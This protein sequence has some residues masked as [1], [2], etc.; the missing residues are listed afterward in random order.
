MKPQSA[1]SV[2]DPPPTGTTH[3]WANVYKAIMQRAHDTLR[4]KWGG[5]FDVAAVK[6]P[7][8]K[9]GSFSVWPRGKKE[10]DGN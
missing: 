6:H 7:T 4:K 9:P 3:L 1:F 10:N 2:T 5:A 8:P